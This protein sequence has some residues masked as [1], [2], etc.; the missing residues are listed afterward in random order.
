MIEA[1]EVSDLV[2]RDALNVGRRPVGRETESDAVAVIG[3]RDAIKSFYTGLRS[4]D[5]DFAE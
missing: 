4:F 2:S 1:C 3:T 5:P